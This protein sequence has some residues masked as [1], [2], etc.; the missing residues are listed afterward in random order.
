MIYIIQKSKKSSRR[1]EIKLDVSEAK[2]FLYEIDA[3]RFRL[4]EYMVY[5]SDE[6]SE[7]EQIIDYFHP[8]YLCEKNDDIVSVLAVNED[9][10]KY[11]RLRNQGASIKS[12]KNFRDKIQNELPESEVSV[13][14]NTNNFEVLIQ[15]EKRDLKI[16]CNYQ[17]VILKAFALNKD[18]EFVDISENDEIVKVVNNI[19]RKQRYY[20]RQK[21]G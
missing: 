7:I 14:F 19:F 13:M 18:W 10:S 1:T 20:Y 6:A 9:I 16:V 4:N 8:D 15:Y 3:R 12:V 21:N 17:L 5:S 11:N 2:E